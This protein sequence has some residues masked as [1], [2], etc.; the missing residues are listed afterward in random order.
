MLMLSEQ[1]SFTEII[2]KT[3]NCTIYIITLSEQ[4]AHLSFSADRHLLAVKK[5]QSIHGNKIIRKK[6]GTNNPVCNEL[7][8]YLAGRRHNFDLTPHPFF[9]NSAS[10]LRQRIWQQIAAIPYG[11]TTTYGDI[12]RKLGNPA[13]ARAVGQAARAN[14]IAMII[15][16]HRVTGANNMGGYAGGTA[17]K[18]HL[19]HLEWENR[20]E[21]TE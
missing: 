5:I 19:L 2:F 10:P 3:R 1:S 13:L 20:K 4:I 8:E 15:P 21:I 6:P 18:K 9:F 17:I 14:P 7:Q 12:G 11:K 16:C